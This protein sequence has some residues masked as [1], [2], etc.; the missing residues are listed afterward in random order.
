MNTDVKSEDSKSVSIG[1]P[2]VAKSSS[3]GRHVVIVGFGVSGRT[4]VNSVI[5]HGLSY[6]VIETNEETV[7][8]CERGGLHILFGDA[9]DP[10]IL[11]QAGIERA[12][13]VAVTVPADQITLAVVEQA[14]KLNATAKIIAR[15]TFVSGGLEA[16]RRGAD[17]VVIVEQVVAT[18]F[19]R[20]V[21][22]A[23][24]R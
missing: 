10:E 18:E 21:S 19:G 23:M 15:C 12:S 2:S 4:T 13:D 17:E 3:A 14:R 9:R 24:S 5:E 20:V 22:A 11:R 6:C 1:A 16:H 7:Q 8:R